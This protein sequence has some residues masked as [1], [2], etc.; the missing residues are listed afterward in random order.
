VEGFAAERDA[1]LV[2]LS[3]RHLVERWI[4]VPYTITAWDEFQT[5]VTGPREV[6]RVIWGL[7]LGFFPM[8]VRIGVG[9]GSITSMP[10]AHEALNAA[11]SGPAFGRAREAIEVLKRR[12]GKYPVLTCFRG[13]EPND[14]AVANGILRTIDTLLLRISRR[15]WETILEVERLSAQ[16]RAAVALGV[17]ASTV[18][19]SLRRA[20]YWQV[21]DAFD[22][23]GAALDV[24]DHRVRR[25]A[26]SAGCTEV[27]Q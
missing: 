20:A 22:L 2:S 11:G 21:K 4:D 16:E 9:R 7:R 3:G 15:Q 25:D 26:S 27:S 12:A 13:A 23:L 8:H 17:D 6:A 19:R 14:E 24:L 1:R 10:E 5:V 18:S